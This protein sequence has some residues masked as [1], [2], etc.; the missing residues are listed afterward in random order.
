VNRHLA[1]AG[2]A[3]LLVLS[4]CAAAPR[5]PPVWFAP[6]LASEDML[7]LFTRPEEWPSARSNV[8]VFK[9]YASQILADETG[10]PEC[11]PN[12]FPSFTSVSAFSRLAG[13]G[14]AIALEVPAIKD[15]GCRA[16]VTAPM[17][18]EAI[19]RVQAG[20][21]SVRYL[22]MDEPLA[23]GDACGYTQAESAA[24]TA[25]FVRA[26]RSAHPEVEIGDIEPYPLH[27][28]QDLASWL[29]AL[30]LEQVS[31]SFLHLD[32]DRVHADRLALDVADDLVS[33]RD[34][35]RAQGVPFGVI[36]WGADGTTDQTYFEDV[37]DWT[38]RVA[39]ALG[40][41]EQTIFQSWA[42]APDGSRTVP[43]NLPEKDP[44]VFSHTRLIDEGLTILGGASQ[45]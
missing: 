13:W 16:A 3:L 34:A 44:A 7:D 20:G 28:V 24:Q 21:G 26:V 1:T 17:A 25:A 12:R 14:I 29:Q 9:F 15:W 32:V 40:R 45:S 10:C 8:T 27:A 33:M 4:A 19:A 6:N 18:L 38:R 42:V 2:A 11:G 22:A 30:S 39:S 36:L 35:C 43:L 37:L 5:K 23:G 41:P 31:L